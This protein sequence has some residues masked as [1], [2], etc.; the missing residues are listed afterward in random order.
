MDL[1]DK[2]I[3]ARLLKCSRDSYR[4]IA[5]DLGVACPTIQNRVDR[6]RQWGVIQ[7]FCV[8]LSHRTLGVRWVVVDVRTNSEEEK[9]ILLKR[10]DDHE[11]IREVLSLGS[12]EYLIFAEASTEEESMCKDFFKQID[13]IESARI[14]SLE[15]IPI[16]SMNGQCRYATLGDNAKLEGIHLDILRCLLMNSRIPINI[17]SKHTG[18]SIKQVRRILEQLQN[19]S[20]IQFTIRLN[21][22]SAG[23]INFLLSFNYDRKSFP[24]DIVNALNHDYPK[25]HWFTSHVPS[26]RK[27]INYMTASNMSRVEEIMDSMKAYHDMNNVEARLVFSSLRSDG[28]SE[29]Y[30]RDYAIEKLLTVGNKTRKRFSGL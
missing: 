8:E 12:G 17:I 18:Y 5:E 13:C 9:G 11:C 29:R 30:L 22:P 23:E 1:I 21:L 24:N 26:S 15:Q 27:V 7:R 14:S 16:K 2:K 6:L 19:H 28:R 25:E 10:F 20:G 4:S 3:I